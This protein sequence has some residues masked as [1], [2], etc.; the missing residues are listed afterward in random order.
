[1]K[2]ALKILSILFFFAFS[3]EKTTAQI[4]APSSVNS[5]LTNYTNGMPNDRIYIF[6]SP[7]A[8]GQNVNG[9]L[10]I[11]GSGGSAPYNFYWFTYNTGTNS[12]NV[13]TTQTGTSSTVSNLASGGYRVAI[14]DAS[15]NPMGCYRA[16]VWVKQTTVDVA[17]ITP[18]C[19]P[20][21]LSGTYNTNDTYTYYNPPPDPFI[22]GAGTTITVCFTAIHTWVSDLGFYLVGPPSCGS[23]F[24]PLAPHPQAIN[25][26]QG[27]CCNNG[28]NVN[29]LCFSTTASNML[30]VC[31][32]PTPL[33]GTYGIYGQGTPNNYNV[34]NNNWSPIYGCDATQGGWRVQIF[35][36]IGADV[37]VLTNATIT[38]SGN[39]TCGPSSITYNSGNINSI[40]NDNSCSQGTASIYTVPN[41]V[42]QSRTLTSTTTYQWSA[43][44]PASISNTTG[45]LT[46]SVNPAPT[47]NTWFYLTVNNSL[48]CSH[49]DS[50]QFIFQPNPP[51]TIT[52]AGP[53]CTDAAPV[54]LT[55]SQNGGT[56]SGNG[57]TNAAN[58]TFNPATAGAGTHTITYTMPPPCG[59]TAT[60]SITVNATP[61][62]SFA[63]SAPAICN[64][65]NVSIT[66]SGANTYSWSPATGLSA[67]TG[68]TVTANPT[69][70]TSYTVNGTGASGCTS[71]GTI[72]VT[73]NPLPV[74]N[75]NPS[76]PSICTGNSVS[77]TAS[78]ANTYSWS[79]ATGLSS[80]SGTTVT[81]NPMATTFYTVTGTD[82]NGCTDSYSFTVIVTTVVSVNVST[83]NP[84]CNG[85]NTGTA[86]ALASTGSAPF[87]Y[88]WSNGQ[89]GTNANGLP[90]GTIDVLVTDAQ[91]CIGTA[92]ATLANPPAITSSVTPFVFPGGNNISCNG[93]SDGSAT[94][95]VS[96][97][98]PPYN[99]LWSNGQT[100]QNLSGANAGNHTVTIIDANNCTATNS[101]TLIEP[102]PINIT[103][104]SPTYGGGY[105]VSCAGLND[106]VINASVSNG[107]SPYSYLW[108]NGA[109]TQNIGNGSAGNNSVTI[110]DANGCS[111]TQTITLIAPPGMSSSASIVTQ[112]SCNGGNNGA[113]DL[114]VVN[115]TGTPT[116]LWSN[117]ATTEDISN[118]TAGN[119]SVLVTDINGCTSTSSVTLT[120]PALL[121]G[122]LTAN[123]ITCNGFDNGSINT[124]VS[125]G[126][127]PYSFSW[128]NGQNTQNIAS[129]SAGNYSLAIT[130][131]NG[132]T[133]NLNT[134]IT[135]PAALSANIAITS[136]STGAY[137][138]SCFGASDAAIIV[139]TTGGTTPY[140]YLWNNG[141]VTQSLNNISAG[142]YSVTVSDNNGCTANDNITLSEPPAV[143]VTTSVINH[144]SCYN[145]NDGSA[146]ASAT[147]GNAPYSF[148]WSSGQ[149][150]ATASNLQAGTHS[151]TVADATGCSVSQNITLTQPAALMVAVSAGTSICIG[152][153]T[154]LNAMPSGGTA[155]YVYN[156]TASP[157]D[158][159]L[160]ASQQNP[161]V[162]PFVTTTYIVSITDDNGCVV[163]S[164]PVT[165]VVQPSL[166]VSLSANPAG[167]CPGASAVITC[168]ATGG[169]GNYSCTVNGTP[170]NYYAPYTATPAATMYYVFRI[171]DGC[172]T[173]PV[174]D[175]VLIT[176]FPAP[177][178]NFSVQ[179]VSGCE[180]LTVSFTDNTLPPP[181]VFAWD[182][183]D[184]N[185][186]TNNSS[187]PSPV[188]VYN[189][190][191]TYSVSLDV[192]TADGCSGSHIENNLITV[193]PNPVAAF[194][195][196]PPATNV[197]DALI[198]FDNNS[199][200]ASSWSWDFGDGDTSSLA[201]P[202]HFYGDT[203]VYTVWLTAYSQQG[204][205]DSAENSVRITPDFMIYIP[206]A[207]TPDANGLND[208]FR[209]YGEGIQKEGFEFRIF[210]RWGEQVFSAF[211]PEA[212]WFGDFN[213]KPVEGGVYVY[214]VLL[215]TYNNKIKDYRGHVVVLR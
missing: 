155:P 11:T 198:T 9:T 17:N 172:G 120:Q 123:N 115:A 86:Q 166:S 81:A 99:F 5:V 140:S 38:F 154:Q 41:P 12:W 173:Q 196:N 91:G 201:N 84:L 128:S 110:T 101:V 144:V 187:S 193:F 133:L 65:D 130:D 72:T 197:L 44:P 202:Q 150:T 51:P 40:I 22:V 75:V 114:T 146:T 152:Q 42:A 96:G 113:I 93:A 59:G 129:L 158:A 169:D 58:G 134:T 76:I 138:V 188:H 109:T 35:D 156:W 191:G 21:A 3:V 19:T 14:T 205:M 189:F 112:I 13:L 206:N 214:S 207:F 78:G 184:N 24:L 71:S 83:T 117:G 145:G 157:A 104:N 10:S 105:N 111:A 52:P 95:T 53:F 213:G 66:A 195:L 92:S 100:S 36:C 46:P 164:D 186:S 54:N 127:S 199:S 132:C 62:L 183:G 61:V 159:S 151:V 102:L 69:T 15:G 2:T 4:T 161:T 63:P 98:T 30:Q 139:N 16:W 103:L 6:C 43:S 149:S 204:C 177:V 29:N 212:Q 56:W 121:T 185:L 126:T 179:P 125:G 143:A 55:A 8:Q 90:A 147:G 28:D 211:D 135:E 141:T 68:S 64:G 194:M 79:P 124:S 26:A 171:S 85:S 45:T 116:F 175:S 47:Q 94:L 73:V 118:L 178:V 170:I 162:S 192:I 119:Y 163:I 108:S 182:F 32:A 137:D 33:T 208:G 165:V 70:T 131:N 180:P 23:P 200:G 87:T 67:T 60:T 160:V 174:S 210:N 20:F 34:N 122:N 18:G 142:N 1:M 49:K 57:I 97:G 168:T 136:F 203:G 88:L 190:P 77:V 209:I 82:V 74:V 176:V 7:N 31:G 181:A 107:V 167:V 80:T 39:S 50:A 89:T 215:K 37:G 148:V 106:G 25:S 153:T 27:C 48:G